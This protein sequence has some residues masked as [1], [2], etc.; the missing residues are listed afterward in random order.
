[1]ARV[2]T[3][4]VLVYSARQL[5]RSISMQ[6]GENQA[7]T[8]KVHGLLKKEVHSIQFLEETYS[9]KVLKMILVNAKMDI[10]LD[11]ITH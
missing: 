4:L 3:K 2:L 8:Q 5:T 1:M 7:T 6:N 10:M 11:A 9:A